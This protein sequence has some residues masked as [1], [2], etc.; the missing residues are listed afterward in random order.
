M[1]KN[2]KNVLQVIASTK[3]Q[4]GLIALLFIAMGIIGFSS[5]KGLGND[6]SREISNMFGGDSEFLL[7]IV[8]TLE[9]IC[10]IFLGAQLIV[11]MIPSSFVT[12][13]LTVIMIFWAVLIIILDVLTIDF[14]NFDGSEWFTWIEQTA[15]H[16]IVLA[17]I[18]RIQD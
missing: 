9:L 1:A 18:I 5:G 14:G 7:Y 3:V 12:L 17:S 11:K 13:A 16:L 2:P 6:I 8:S 10:G 15:L 4:Q